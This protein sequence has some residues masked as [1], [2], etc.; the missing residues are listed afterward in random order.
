MYMV[1]HSVYAGVWLRATE[2]DI[3]AA[4]WVTYSSDWILLNV[5][6]LCVVIGVCVPRGCTV[7]LVVRDVFS[8]AEVKVYMSMEASQYPLS[9][10]PGA[11]FHFDTLQKK[12]SV[13][14]VAY[15]VFS[16]ASSCYAVSLANS[17]HTAALHDRSVLTCLAKLDCIVCANNG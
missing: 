9:M 10:M 12:S 2:T 4:H 3:S 14:G 5:S 15:Y 13:N 8:C 17:S 7:V 1:S 11:T 16:L 6:L